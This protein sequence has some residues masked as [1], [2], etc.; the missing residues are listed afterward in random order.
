M[1]SAAFLIGVLLCS[2]HIQV[3]LVTSDSC[4]A[5]T[6]GI[7]GTCRS[8]CRSGWIPW[9]GA[10]YWLAKDHFN[11][12][13]A[14]DAC[15]K[16]GGSLAAPRSEEENVFVAGIIQE[17]GESRVWIN[18]DDLEREDDW[19]CS[20]DEVESHY[21]NWNHGEPNN[22]RED[23]HCAMVLSGRW[24]A[25][26][27][28][29]IP[30]RGACYWLAKDHF[31]WFDARDACRK[32]GGFLAAPRSEEENDFVTGIIQDGGEGRVWINCNDLG[33][34]ASHI[35]S[36]TMF[37]AAFLIVALLCTNHIQV[38]LATSDS[39]SASTHGIT[40]R[41]VC[42]SGWIPWKGACYLLVKDRFNWFDARDACRK[43]GG[44]LA[45]QRSEEENDFVTGII[46]EG[47]EGRVWINCNDLEREGD[48]KCSHDGVESHYFNWNLGEPSNARE[49]CV[50]IHFS[51]G[52][53]DAFCSKK[54][55]VLCKS[56]QTTLHLY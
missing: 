25:C 30:W 45:A 36:V 55:L 23:E 49:D 12:F 27:S 6:H 56:F 44:S 22:A 41:S 47:G 1:I 29:W 13:D 10:C 26:R 3:A 32:M 52:W 8:A 19:K 2:N 31:N 43:M 17:G 54:Y 21:F 20:N 40:G 15:R 37:S 24:S 51:G 53:A 11:W 34:E 9:R 16:M 38:A 5:S 7:T 46:Q 48:W 39:C 18:C 4:S 50:M 28:G 33:R 14:R 42:R 35:C